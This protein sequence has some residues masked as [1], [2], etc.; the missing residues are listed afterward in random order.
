MILSLKDEIV[1]RK[2]EIKA[3]IQSIYFGGGTP[4]LL[5]EK[6]LASLI[7]IVH[8]NYS[9]EPSAE[10]TLEANP[11]NISLEAALSWKNLGVNRLS[12][13]LQSFK[14]ADLK[15]MNRGH[16]NN[17]NSACVKTVY[18]AGF[19]NVSIDLI[20]GLPGLKNSEWEGF[21]KKVVSLG[22][23]HISAYCLTIEDKTKLKY[24]VENETIKPLSEKKQIEQFEFLC[25]FLKQ[26]GYEHYEVSNF[27]LN[28]NYSKHNRSYWDRKEYIGI[29]PSAHS[30]NGKGRRWNVSNNH[31]YMA[32]GT[33]AKHW[34]SREDLSI[35]SVWNE[36]FLTGFRTKWGVLKK[37]IE[38][39]GGLT[40]KEQKEIKQMIDNGD[41][42]DSKNAYVLSENGLLFADAIS[43]HFFRIS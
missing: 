5:N 35:D 38:K 18:D 24:D 14:D 3:P 26:S 39:L 19:N 2:N 12:I 8:N 37:D 40:R 20:Y 33:K 11:E 27:A 22:V 16:N 13:G 30:Y 43:E 4:S 9:V 15:W 6:E 31:T 34:Y 7:E 21:L 28:K 25:A 23:E 36:L 17:Q 1:L 10:V 29:G 41:L 42:I 32:R